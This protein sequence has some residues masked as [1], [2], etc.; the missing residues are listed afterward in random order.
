MIDKFD[1]EKERY[2]IAAMLSECVLFEYH[3]TSKTLYKFDS[4]GDILKDFDVIRNFRYNENFCRLIY[5]K[6]LDRFYEFCNKLDQ[7]EERLKL[8][9]RLLD[10]HD[11]YKWLQIK[12][13]TIYDERQNPLKVIGKIS[14]IDVQ[15]KEKEKLRESKTK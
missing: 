3:I 6:D 4:Y 1:L 8:D 13:R 9:I 15:I 14:N 2:K 12:G 10:S 5:E 7:G 11:E